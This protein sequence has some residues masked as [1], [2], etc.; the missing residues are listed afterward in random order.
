MDKLKLRPE[1]VDLGRFA[2][3]K[4]G[5]NIMIKKGR[6]EEGER[7]IP[8]SQTDDGP[9]EI[10]TLNYD[11]TQ[12][13]PDYALAHDFA[14]YIRMAQAPRDKRLIPISTNKTIK[15]VIR[16]LRNE[17]KKA[18][19]SDPFNGQEL[20]FY[21]LS[22]LGQLI[23]TP[24]NFW[25]TKWLYERYP[26]LKRESLKGLQRIFA[27]KEIQL[28]LANA[29]KFP[30]IYLRSVNALDAVY[31]LFLD[32]LFGKIKFFKPYVGTE[33]EAIAVDLLKLNKKDRGYAG[34]IEAI[35][36]W[37]KVLGLKGWFIWVKH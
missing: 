21:Y 35:N 6:L 19:G 20:K 18:D 16:Q 8:I 17:F 14:K 29:K 13:S 12:S 28:K 3:K 27:L 4:I 25:I 23:N 37:S 24:G 10:F 5:C 32:E 34:D 36:V 33:F 31:A 7:L 15:R 26:K 22:L 9:Q 2:A 30:G 11:L 1:L